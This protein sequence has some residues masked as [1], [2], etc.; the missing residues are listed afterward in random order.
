MGVTLVPEAEI[1]VHF[2]QHPKTLELMGNCGIGII[3]P[4]TYPFDKLTRNPIA[5]FCTDF[6]SQK[7]IDAI[8]NFCTQLLVC[9]LWLKMVVPDKNTLHNISITYISMA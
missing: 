4:Y 9:K 2:S 7:Y 8:V 5:Y 1:L 6:M 3:L